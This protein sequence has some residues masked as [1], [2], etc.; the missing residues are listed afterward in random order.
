MVKLSRVNHSILVLIW[1]RVF[2]LITPSKL[3]RAHHPGKKTKKNQKNKQTNKQTNNQTQQTNGCHEYE[4]HREI[5]VWL[6]TSL[7]F[8]AKYVGLVAAHD[9]G[10][11]A[12]KRAVF[13][14]LF[15]SCT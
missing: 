7:L 4:Q 15:V 12:Q 5:I 8:V 2:H 9:F 6:P 10:E 1:V 11:C 13:V 14:F 3:A